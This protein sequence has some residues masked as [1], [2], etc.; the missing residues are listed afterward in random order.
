V[1]TKP[2]EDHDK[3]P[4]P[5]LAERVH[6]LAAT[7]GWSVK[8]QDDGNWALS[9]PDGLTRFEDISLGSVALVIGINADTNQK[10][11]TVLKR[12]YADLFEGYDLFEH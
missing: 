2:R 4:A 11:D 12:Y 3:L 5:V 7:T 8:K 10:P 1:S 9:D 6:Q